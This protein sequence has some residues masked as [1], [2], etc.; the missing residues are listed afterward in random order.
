MTARD[1]RPRGAC[2][3]D[4][5]V[6]PAPR[7]DERAG[8]GPPGSR[9]SP[10]LPAPRPPRRAGNHA[11]IFHPPRR[12]DVAF[13]QLARA[14]TPRGSRRRRRRS[15]IKAWAQALSRRRRNIKAQTQALATPTV[16]SDQRIRDLTLTPALGR[17]YSLTTYD[18]LSTCLTFKEKTEPTRGSRV[19]LNAIAASS[20]RRRRVRLNSLAPVSD[21]G[22]ISRTTSTRSAPTGTCPPSPKPR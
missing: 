20:P 16:I 21:A 18:V 12:S 7:T 11:A 9:T 5:D 1:P 13:R 3:R 14:V 2:S 19:E 6:D 17:G 10:H 22:T 8:A 15:N 4:L